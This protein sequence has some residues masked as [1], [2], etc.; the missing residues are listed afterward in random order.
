MLISSVQDL[1]R[2]LVEHNRLCVGSNQADLS[3]ALQLHKVLNLLLQ[4]EN[5]VLLDELRKTE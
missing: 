2:F 5:V 3:D 1:P 4:S